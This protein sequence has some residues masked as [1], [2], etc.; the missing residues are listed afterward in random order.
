MVVKLLMARVVV[1][2]M[3]SAAV[4]LMVNGEC[5]GCAVDGEW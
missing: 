3:V 4:L 2:V 1:L 5:G